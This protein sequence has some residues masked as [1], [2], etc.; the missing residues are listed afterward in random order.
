MI[1][2]WDKLYTIDESI[3]GKPV[4][5]RRA[6]PKPRRF[7][8]G[9]EVTQDK[10]IPLKLI[11]Q[12]PVTE[13]SGSSEMHLRSIGIWWARKCIYRE[14]MNKHVSASA[15]N[16]STANEET[17]TEV[18]IRKMIRQALKCI[19]GS[20]LDEHRSVYMLNDGT[21]NQKITITSLPEDRFGVVDPSFMKNPKK[22]FRVVSE[23]NLS[24]HSRYGPWWPSLRW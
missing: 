9:H 6:V 2:H 11:W 1:V 18:H 12:L 21:Y 10:C 15:D 8:G 4:E 24:W 23:F 13:Q 16:D 19:Y 22:P 3:S 17:S 5:G 7:I 20:W 14:R